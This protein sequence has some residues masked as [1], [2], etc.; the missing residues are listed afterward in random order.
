M[1]AEPINPVDRTVRALV[2]AVLRQ[3]VLD[4]NAMHTPKKQW[5]KGLGQIPD[6][7]ARKSARLFLQS[8]DGQ[9]MALKLGITSTKYKAVLEKI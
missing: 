2:A 5:K 7:T 6:E 9:A 1:L 8:E 3:A 4:L